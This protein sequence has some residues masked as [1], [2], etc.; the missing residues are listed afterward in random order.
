[1]LNLRKL[2]INDKLII[3]LNK[4]NADYY[5]KNTKRI[6]KYCD[7]KNLYLEVYYNN[8]KLNE[9]DLKDN[10]NS[11]LKDIISIVHAINIKDKKERFVYIYDTVCS[12]LDE[13]IKKTNYCRFIDDVCIRDRLNGSYHKNGCCDCKG[14]G[15]CKYLIDSK[16]TE[17]NCIACKL[18]TCHTLEL[19]GYKQDINDFVL[20]KY[21]FTEK[22]KD[23]LRFSYWTP[24]DIIIDRLLKNKYVRP[25]K[26]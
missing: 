22:Q 2:V 17:N 1:M 15:K 4:D 20:V 24:K 23:I 3:K 13:K 7:N 25:K 16:C 26:Y 12:S 6:R 21:F 9:L 8:I 10:I 14:R 5:L 11:N 18:F 19:R